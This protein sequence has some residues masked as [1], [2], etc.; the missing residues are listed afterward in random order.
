MESG[1]LE[2][3]A[4]ENMDGDGLKLKGNRQ[5]DR[6]NNQLLLYL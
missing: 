6:V 2:L 5:W 1:G 3:V 4:I